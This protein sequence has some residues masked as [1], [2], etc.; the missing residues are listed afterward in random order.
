MTQWIAMILTP[1]VMS[2]SRRKDVKVRPNIG[3]DCFSLMICKKQIAK[4]FDLAIC[5]LCFI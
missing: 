4:S 1:S 5:F 3:I 2:V